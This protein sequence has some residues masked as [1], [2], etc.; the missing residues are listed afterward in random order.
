M[1]RFDL[2]ISGAEFLELTPR[3]FDKLAIRLLARMER[4]EF[5]TG[6][7]ASQI[8]N[9]SMGAPSTPFGPDDFVYSVPRKPKEEPRQTTE[10][11]FAVFERAAE[12]HR[13]IDGVM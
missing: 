6:I 5:L 8:G 9:F 13:G 12:V 1:A 3:L 7:L 2:R 4:E 10:S 11:I